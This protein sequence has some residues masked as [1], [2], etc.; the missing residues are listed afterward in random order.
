MTPQIQFLRFA[1]RGWIDRLRWRLCWLLMPSIVLGREKRRL[2]S[3]AREN[4]AS[5]KMAYGIASAYFNTL[6]DE[7]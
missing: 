5:K 6:R 4:G 2:E 7:R 1:G 3:I